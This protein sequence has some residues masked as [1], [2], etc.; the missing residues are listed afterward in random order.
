MKKK[1]A[2]TLSRFNKRICTA[3][4][5]RASCAVIAQ[6]AFCYIGNSLKFPIQQRT[7]SPFGPA[8]PVR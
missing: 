8:V 5:L 2:F 4:V 1:C 6:N 7:A 3:F